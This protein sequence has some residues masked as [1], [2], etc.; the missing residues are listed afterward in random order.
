MSHNEACVGCT[1]Q[2]FEGRPRVLALTPKARCALAYGE[3]IV[4]QDLFSREQ[5]DAIRNAG[6]DVFF[7]RA[8]SLLAGAK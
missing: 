6:Y 7:V 2:P 4:P 1:P 3:R 8:E 5:F